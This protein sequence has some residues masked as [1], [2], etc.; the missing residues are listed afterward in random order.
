MRTPEQ[1]HALI[2]TLS[3]TLPVRPD[4]E[5]VR[6]LLAEAFVAHIDDLWPAGRDQGSPVWIAAHVDGLLA[7]IERLYA[8]ATS[9]DH[10]GADEFLD[11]MAW[12]P[13]L[14]TALDSDCAGRR[15]VAV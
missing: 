7:T 10:L 9:G 13:T 3:A 2:A 8:L 6:G 11:R 1:D 14:L 4:A 15:R 12:L 5:R